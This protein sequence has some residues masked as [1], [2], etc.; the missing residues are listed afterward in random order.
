MYRYVHRP[1]CKKENTARYVHTGRV[2]NTYSRIRTWLGRNGETMSSSCS[3]G[4]NRLGWN[5]MCRRVHRDVLDGKGDGNEA[6]HT[7]EKRKRPCVRP[8]TFKT[9]SCPLGGVWRTAKR[10]KRTSY[11][12]NG[13]P[14]DREGCGVP[15]NGVNG[16]VLE[17]YGRNGGHVHRE[18]CGVPQN[19]TP[20]DT[21][22]LHRRPPPASTG[23]CSSSLHGLLFI[24]PP[25]CATP[26]AT[27]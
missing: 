1:V 12:R 26:L 2:S 9:G 15:Q 3:W 16:L 25:P 4:A 8:A 19:R 7:A 21:V 6:W 20:R 18:G 24:Q 14:V 17:R 22:H 27:I 23:S 11:G 10:R 13:G 5:G